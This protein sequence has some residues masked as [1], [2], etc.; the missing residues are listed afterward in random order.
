MPPLEGTAKAIV[1]Y[2]HQTWNSLI[3]AARRSNATSIANLE[4]GPLGRYLEIVG[5]FRSWP[6]HWRYLAIFAVVAC[7]AVVRSVVLG[8][9][10]DRL[11]Y[12]TFNPAVAICAIIG[13]FASGMA[14]MIFSAVAAHTLIAPFNSGI[15]FLGLVAF[16]IGGLFI[17]TASEALHHIW[18]LVS[19]AKTKNT[20]ERELCLFIQNSPIAAAMFDK[21]MRYMAVSARWLSDYKLTDSLIGRSHYEVFP[22]IPENWREAHRRGL[23]GE[24]LSLDEDR[25]ARASG[26]SQWLNWEI[27]PWFRPLGEIGGIII[28]TEDI[29]QKKLADAEFEAVEQRF[30][31]ALEASGGGA[32]DWHLGSDKIWWSQEMYELWGIEKG[33]PITFDSIV[34]MINRE[35]IE[36]VMRGID[37]SLTHKSAH[38]TEFRIDHPTRGVRWMTSHGRVLPGGDDGNTHLVGLTFDITERKQAEDALVNIRRLDALGQLAGGITHD[39]NNLLTVISCNLQLAESRI[40][41]DASKTWIRRAIDATIAGADS[42]RRLMSLVGKSMLQP[43]HVEINACVAKLSELLEKTVGDKI[44]LQQQY[45]PGQLIA[46]VDQS[47][48]NNALVNLAL[49][50]RDAMQGGGTLIISTEFVNLTERDA[51]LLGSKAIPGQFIRI[52]VIDN[53]IG[54]S[55]TELRRA[56]EPLFTTKVMGKGTGLGLSSVSAFVQHS[57]GFMH[58]KSAVGSGTTVSL[59]LPKVD[60]SVGL[61]DD[62][63]HLSSD[64][65]TGNGERVFV[66]EDNNDLRI[67]LVERIEALGYKTVPSPNGADAI[68]QLKKADNVSLVFSDVVMPGG[69]SGFDLA[70]W[71]RTNR[72]SIGILLTSGFYTS[73]EMRGSPSQDQGADF[74]VLGKP[75]T[76]AE[77]AQRLRRAIDEVRVH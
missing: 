8:G 72:P 31:W 34:S 19:A 76:T 67:A 74:E 25:F 55:D 49:N 27:R 12:V 17:S 28:F 20:S 38:R 9:L 77:L 35:D 1:H 39:F 4:S 46:H 32:W 47:A 44:V 41:D 75:Y 18:R 30:R 29:T 70:R 36:P 42:N 10:G 60:T 13:G 61:V 64:I 65:P 23:Q 37:R 2:A 6:W 50:A 26:A 51:A 69:V 48:L 58:I 62:D 54:M 7:A 53:G 14:A 33:R 52:S 24:V 63:D 21:D 3:A 15:D 22:E 68:A 59:Y 71:I 43:H 11:V 16:C 56:G 73:D 40:T 5:N 57:S 66:V 45:A